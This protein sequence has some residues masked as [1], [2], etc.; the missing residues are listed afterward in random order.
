MSGIVLLLPGSMVYR[1]LYASLGQD[2]GAVSGVSTL[3]T[4]GL[5]GLALAAGVSL[6]TFFGRRFAR[7]RTS[8]GHL[9]ALAVALRRSRPDVRE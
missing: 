2:A 8:T 3:A 1:G 9:D 7:G 6:G 5:V 4:A